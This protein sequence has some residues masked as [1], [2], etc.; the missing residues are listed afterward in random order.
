MCSTYLDDFLIISPP[1]ATGKD[2]LRYVLELCRDLGVPIAAHKTRGPSDNHQVSEDR[3]GYYGQD[4][5]TP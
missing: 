5:E 3:A 2:D 4:S 1:E